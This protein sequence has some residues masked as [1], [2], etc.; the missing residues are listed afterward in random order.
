MKF[1]FQEK[2]S[3]CSPDNSDVGRPLSGLCI[4]HPLIPLRLLWSSSGSP[5]LILHVRAGSTVGLQKTADWKIPFLVHNVSSP[6]L[7]MASL[8]HLGPYHLYFFWRQFGYVV[9]TGLASNYV[10][11]TDLKPGQ[12]S[13]LNPRGGITATLSLCRCFHTCLLA[14]CPTYPPTTTTFKFLVR[15]WEV[16]GW[17]GRQLE[18]R[19]NTLS[20][21][22]MQALYLWI[23]PARDWKQENFFCTENVQTSSCSYSLN[24]TA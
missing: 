7:W 6:R 11:H 16:A 22:Y 23:E 10:T 24:N 5:T 9:H 14:P 4:T 21:P 15:R 18:W 1:M 12:S 8:K 19:K 13:C 3:Q 20:P 17:K 2:Q